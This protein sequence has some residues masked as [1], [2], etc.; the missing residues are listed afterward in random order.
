MPNPTTEKGWRTKLAGALGKEAGN[1]LWLSQF[2]IGLSDEQ[3][4]VFVSAAIALADGDATIALVYESDKSDHALMRMETVTENMK[5][6]TWLDEA[7]GLELGTVV[8]NYGL[9]GAN[10]FRGDLVYGGCYMLPENHRQLRMPDGNQSLGFVVTDDTNTKAFIALSEALDHPLSLSMVFSHELAHLRN[11][12]LHTDDQRMVEAG[13]VG[14]AISRFAPTLGHRLAE[15]CYA[16]IIE[17]KSISSL[18]RD[19]KL[20]DLFLASKNPTMR[21]IGAQFSRTVVN[22][23]AIVE[24]WLAKTKPIKEAKGIKRTGRKW[25][26]RFTITPTIV[27]PSIG[28]AVHNGLVLIER[29]LRADNGQPI[30]GERA[31]KGCKVCLVG[32][33]L[34]MLA[35]AA[36]T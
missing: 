25:E 18:G 33:S 2:L 12:D 6:I 13:A 24:R 32:D 19:E 1:M 5:Q 27:G 21:A 34:R 3:Q 7:F 26:G 20:R 4:A 23:H 17:G 22:K 28:K 31:C 8:P 36:A 15:L 30:C 10:K 35:A 29:W 11:R 9:T 16:T 14:N